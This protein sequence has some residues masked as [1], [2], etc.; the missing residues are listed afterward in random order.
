MKELTKKE[1]IKD[2]YL[3]NFELFEK[4]M[5]G[6]NHELLKKVRQA[7]LAKFL[8]LDFPAT[9]NEEWK[10]TD[11]S[12]AR[13]NKFNP[14]ST[15]YKTSLTKEDVKNIIFGNFDYNLIT[16]INGKFAAELS[17]ISADSDKIIIKNLNSFIDSHKEIVE[18]YFAKIS[19]DDNLFNVLNGIYMQDGVAIYL[20]EQSEFSKPLQVLY[21]NGY[22]EENL[23]IA[24]RN[25]IVVGRN[26]RTSIVFNYYGNPKASYF[27]D[28][29]TELYL[30][31]DSS[32]DI[33]K[34]QRESL[35]SYHIEKFQAIQKD[36][37]VLNHYNLNFGGRLTRNDINSKLDGENIETHYYG[38]YLG[39]ENQHIDNHTFV[40]HAKPNSMSNEL[41]KGILD[42]KARGVFNGKIIVRRDAQKTNAYQQNKNVLLSGE[43][44]IDS[45][46][47]L[48][49]F[50]DDVKCTH[51]ATVGHL[52]EEAE[53]Y[54]RSRGVPEELAKSILIRAFAAD[55]CDEIKIVELKEQINH[56]I[57]EELHR[58]EVSY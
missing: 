43:A 40:D 11:V 52:D 30:E 50:A 23:L 44:R 49:I 16:F 53:F 21:L 14:V 9:K 32:V 54:I 41:Y 1:N 46:P 31:E 22:S 56:L 42:D 35:S 55:V 25:L 17:D 7:S 20:K 6:H 19:S 26:S 51:G 18:N 38:L 13:E 10:Y 15:D 27:T 28:A 58:Q 36:R 8:E 29:I 2:W 3:K 34:I 37:S 33:Y 24:P 5:N 12:F 47:Q 45:K 39:K 57:F 48:E 4:Q